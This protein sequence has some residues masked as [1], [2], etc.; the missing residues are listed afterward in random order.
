MTCKKKHL[1][2]LYKILFFAILFGFSIFA[3]VLVK[4]QYSLITNGFV[5]QLV[6]T[7]GVIITLFVGVIVYFKK[8]LT[9]DAAILMIF[10]ISYFVRLGYMLYT[11]YD[12]RQYDTVV[13]SNNGHEGYAWILYTT[14]ALPITN[15]YQFYHPPLNA[16]IQAMFMHISTG[17][18]PLGNAIYGEGT[19][20][21]TDMNVLFQSC[22]ILSLLYMNIAAYIGVKTIRAFHLPKFLDL[23]CSAFV[24]LFP[25]LIQL[26]GQLNNDPICIMFCF[27]A[28][29][30][31]LKWWRE[32]TFK[33]IILLAL[34]IG[35]AL[36]S[37]LNGGTICL[38]TASIFIIEFVKA[39]M[40]KDKHRIINICLQYIVFLAICAPIGLWYQVFSMYRFGQP[41]GY[42]FSNLN[43]GLSTA[44][45]SVFDRFFNIFDFEDLSRGIFASSWDDKNLYI[46]LVRSFIFGEF[47]FWHAEAFA[48][49][50]V[51]A[52][53]LLIISTVVFYIIYLVKAK[54]DNAE[55]KLFSGV[56][57]FTQ[58]ACLVYFYI[59]MPYG[60]TMDARY[61]MPSIIGF[62]L[63][64][65]FIGK[66]SLKQECFKTP[67]I[68]L[69]SI[70]AVFIISSN[71]FYL[72]AI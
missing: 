12:V 36:F 3:Y 21:I 29:Y 35:F 69:F 17:I 72:M 57:V 18:L 10:I 71:I 60:C 31:T 30:Y 41:F 34:A 47:S 32:K 42:V 27:F 2:L 56:L 19:F 45:Y 16:F 20:D 53:Y 54:K 23:L 52:N 13:S 1:Q 63:M 48:L 33:N 46:Y 4:P 5:A 25:R 37:K 51:I 24:C 49:I 43:Q 11:P 40:S 65:G 39:I 50:A 38:L 62:A 44:G 7:M 66:E 68:V 28:V 6:A 22:Q 55:G 14:G 67:A 61:I 58:C 8:K 70:A 64:L 26:S 59:A 15:E 9:T